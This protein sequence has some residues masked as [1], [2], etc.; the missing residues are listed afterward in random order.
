VEVIPKISAVSIPSDQCDNNNSSLSSVSEQKSLENR[1]MD[2][3]LELEYKRKVSDE[4]KQRNTEKKLLRELANQNV[5]SGLS[6]DTIITIDQQ[7]K[8]IPNMSRENS[9]HN[10]SSNNSGDTELTK[11]HS[12]TGTKCHDQNGAPNVDILEL[13]NQIVEGFVQE[14]TS[15][16]SSAS[17]SA[18]LNEGGRHF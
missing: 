3:F 8:N 14:L 17:G 10:N 1:E 15:E 5:T 6:C 12:E 9:G 4:I 7:R 13:E 2:T 11:S 18:S 16:F